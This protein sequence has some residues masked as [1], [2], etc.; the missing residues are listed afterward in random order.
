LEKERKRI[1][2]E[3]SVIEQDRTKNWTL[4]K[5]HADQFIESNNEAEPDLGHDGEIRYYQIA[6]NKALGNALHVQRDM[7]ILLDD[8]STPPEFQQAWLTTR[9]RVII[10]VANLLFSE[11][12]EAQASATALQPTDS[13][14]VLQKPLNPKVYPKHWGTPPLQGKESRLVSLSGGYGK[15]SLE[16]EDWI[17]TNLKSDEDKGILPTIILESP[18]HVLP[19]NLI[20]A[21]NGYKQALKY[22]QSYRSQIMLRQ[23]IAWCHERLDQKKEAIETYKEI[24]HLCEMHTQDLSATLKVVLFMAKV[25]QDG[26]TQ[27]LQQ[28][29]DGQ[30]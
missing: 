3:I 2:G 26:L 1:L 13:T 19:Q 21:I 8:E 11:A 15:G 18:K 5:N 20:L 25:K 30:K 4:L 10:D 7:Q 23:Q 6:A 17:K 29:K 28:K 16:L 14:F 12:V 24:R 27:E 9:V 22:D